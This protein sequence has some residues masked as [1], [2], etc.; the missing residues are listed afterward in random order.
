MLRPSRPMMR[1]FSSS[2]RSST[3]DT[4]V[5]IAWPPATRCMTVERMLRARRSASC[6][7]SS[8]TWRI[9]RRRLVAQLVLEL[10]HQQLLG[11]PRAEAR[12]PLQLAHLLAARLLELGDLVLQV[13]LAVLQGLLAGLLGRLSSPAGAPRGAPARRGGPAARPPPRGSPS[14]GALACSRGT[15]R[16]GPCG[17]RRR[18]LLPVAGGHPAR[19]R[20]V[21]ARARDP[22]RARP[23]RTLPRPP[24]PPGRS[25]SN[26][27]QSGARAVAI[28][29]SSVRLGAVGL[30]LLA[31]ECCG[32]PLGTRDGQRSVALL[33]SSPLLKCSRAVFK[34]Q[35]A[36]ICT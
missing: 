2:E 4:V 16:P 6:L 32:V 30:R 9:T 31:G 20:P 15:R 21:P 33:L 19:L 22:S 17:R 3:T 13:S 11:L 24:K 26:P 34:S 36:A 23:P 7:V 8:S 25:P 35:N 12:Q 18:G 1:P 29:S 28:S 10:A 27:P 14:G 5:S